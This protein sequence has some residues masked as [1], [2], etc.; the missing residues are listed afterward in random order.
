MLCDLADISDP[1]GPKN[2]RASR[3]VVL[4][5]PSRNFD[6]STPSIGR[7][8]GTLSDAPARAAKVLYQSWAESI[9]WLTTPAGVLPGQ[10]TMAAVRIEP[11]AGG[12]E[13]SPRQ[14][15]FE[16]PNPNAG[17]ATAALS[18]EKTMTVLSA[19]PAPSTQST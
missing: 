19:R 6:A 15:P 7:S 8:V 17:T 18:L 2:K 13:K 5:W 11:S 12:V 9:S 16:P 10:R 1:S 4:L 3:P 14:G